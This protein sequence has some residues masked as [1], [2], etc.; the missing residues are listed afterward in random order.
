MTAKSQLSI[1]LSIAMATSVSHAQ[2][3]NSKL[4]LS[5]DPPTNIATEPSVID[6]ESVSK[7]A[8]RASR[9]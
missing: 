3:A 2:T 8:Q 1:F 6:V 7:Y 9:R 4:E 5:L